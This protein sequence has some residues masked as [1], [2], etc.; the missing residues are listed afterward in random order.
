MKGRH[1]VMQTELFLD[2]FSVSGI[3]FYLLLEGDV[4][5]DDWN[6]HLREFR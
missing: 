6:T 4:N 5:E 2:L 1:T 3:Q